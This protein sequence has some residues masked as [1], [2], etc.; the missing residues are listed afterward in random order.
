MQQ[1]FNE[2]EQKY[3]QSKQE[4]A[5]VRGQIAAKTRELKLSQAMESELEKQKVDHVWT[6][7]GKMFMKTSMKEHTVQVQQERAAVQEQIK[8]LEKKETY[9]ETTHKNVANAINE[10]MKRN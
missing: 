6:G 2:I 3:V 4:L 1:A 9:L 5:V 10:I 8:A 7:V